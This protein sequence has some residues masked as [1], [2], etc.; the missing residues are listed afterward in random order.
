MVLTGA[1]TMAGF[2]ACGVPLEDHAAMTP[3]TDLPYELEGAPPPDTVEAAAPGGAAAVVFLL[4]DDSLVEVPRTV[5]DPTNL[6]GLLTE[7]AAPL[8]PAETDEGL[9]RALSDI[10]LIGGVSR[11]A[12]VAT[13]DL[14]PSFDELVPHEQVLALGQI[15]YTLTERDEVDRV[16]FTRDGEPITIPIASGSLVDGSVT[17]YDYRSLR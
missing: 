15:V 8:T 10:G 4:R 9:R 6:N 12:N 2:G 3:G 14:D 13:V 11:T 5:S 17:R 7:L 16:R 1:L